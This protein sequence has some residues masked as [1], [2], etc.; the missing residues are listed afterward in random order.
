MSLTYGDLG[1]LTAADHL[2]AMNATKSMILPGPQRRQAAVH[3]DGQYKGENHENSGVQCGQHHHRRHRACQ[4]LHGEEPVQQYPGRVFKDAGV[5]MA[6]EKAPVLNAV[7]YGPH[8]TALSLTLRSSQFSA[9]QT[10]PERPPYPPAHACRTSPGANPGRRRMP[11]RRNGFRC[12]Q[13]YGR[14]RQQVKAAF[15]HAW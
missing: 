3:L 4:V 8:K 1:K 6:Y 10:H 15:A 2:E 9:C 7:R 12:A 14:V 13:E 11:R 5:R